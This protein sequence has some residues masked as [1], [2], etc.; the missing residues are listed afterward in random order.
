[1]MSFRL[2]TFKYL[3]L[4]L[5]IQFIFADSPDWEDDPLGYLATATMTAVV[6]NNDGDALGDAGDILAAF[7]S[8]GTRRSR[9][10]DQNDQLQP[11]PI[12][13]THKMEPV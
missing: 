9:I 7:D 10:V 13:Q 5:T 12:R 3:S 2:I 8:D 6:L 11:E 1:M 4:F